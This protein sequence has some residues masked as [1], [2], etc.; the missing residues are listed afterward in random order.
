MH[1]L[2]RWLIARHFTAT[3]PAAVYRSIHTHLDDCADCREH[4]ARH[5]EW[6]ALLPDASDR[7]GARMLRQAEAQASAEQSRRAVWG[8]S[9]ATAA[10]AAAVLLF[11]FRQAEPTGLQARGPAAQTRLEMEVRLPGAERFAASTTAFQPG[12]SLGFR[13]DNA[14][15]HGFLVLVLL[16]SQGEVHLLYPAENGAMGR[17]LAGHPP[18]ALLPDAFSPDLPAGPFHAVALL[19]ATAL[20]VDEVE[21]L[22]TKQPLEAARQQL[23]RRGYAIVL[24][25]RA[26]GREDGG[27]P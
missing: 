8:L 7:I 15:G 27:A 1:A 23:E 2:Y 11:T 16:D 22:L 25:G 4:F 5:L 21:Q 17:P 24:Q 19:T 12:S 9:L 6:E 14:A 10:A 13:L 26:A 18:G 20:S 3:V